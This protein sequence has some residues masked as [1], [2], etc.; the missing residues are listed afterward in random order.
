MDNKAPFFEMPNDP[1]EA[2]APAYYTSIKI[3]HTT[4][5][6]AKHADAGKIMDQALRGK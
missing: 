4:N 5:T 6:K 3:P 2:H 1:S